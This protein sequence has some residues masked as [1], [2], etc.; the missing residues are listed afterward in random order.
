MN[1]VQINTNYA[2]TR[3]QQMKSKHI[4]FQNVSIHTES[5]GD[6]KSPPVLLVMGAMCSAVWWPDEFCNMLAESKRFV[7]RY[8]HRDTGLSTC[9]PPGETKYSVE[10][11]A[12]DVIEVLNGY[13]IDSAHLIG[14]S[15]GGF[16]SQLI[17]IKYPGYVKSLTLI[18]SERLA[19]SD[20]N[21]PAMDPKILEYHKKAESLD[22]SDKQAVVEYQVGAWRLLSGSAHPFNKED[23]QK[24]AEMDFDRSP[25]LL[26]SFNHASLAGGD[27]WVG[28]L[29][30]IKQP[31]L[32]VHG[33]EDNVLPYEHGLALNT[34]LLHSK[35]LTLK[36]SGHE[37]HRDDW[38]VIIREIID[39]TT[40]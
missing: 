1:G 32:I 9:Y 19:E 37:L 29:H 6:P 5:F 7:I 25:N 18:A 38:P 11:L 16:L 14:M 36:C 10:D 17:A 40:G 28:R 24:I 27:Q 35:L 22:W 4:S 20:P 31:A 3:I 39:H 26:S 30:D 15:L 8:D 23:I 12:D 2:Q 21:M 34:E 33:T 13:N